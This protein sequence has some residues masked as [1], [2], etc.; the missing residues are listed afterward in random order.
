MAPAL[1]S[2]TCGGTVKPKRVSV[3]SYVPGASPLNVNW[4]VPSVTATC[5]VPAASCASTVTPGSTPP[6]VSVTV[7]EIAPSWAMAM[8]G[9]HRTAAKISGSAKPTVRD[10]Q[11]LE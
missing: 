5:A 10:V 8:P 4:P 9:T 11:V 6:V 2:T 3:T 7:P 1:T